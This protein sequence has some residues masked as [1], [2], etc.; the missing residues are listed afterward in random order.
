MKKTAAKKMATGTHF[1]ILQLGVSIWNQWRA[2]EP[3]TVPNLKNADLSELHLE[4]INLCRANLRGAKLAKAYLYDADFQGADLRE[5]NLTRA[6]LIGA[7]LHKANLSG[8]VLKQAYLAQS[9]LSNAD[10]TGAQ[11]QK[12]DLKD[13]LLTQADFANAR[14][15]EAELSTSFDLTQQQLNSTRDA[16]LACFDA[17][18]AAGL[19]LA[20]NLESGATVTA[21]TD[22]TAIENAIVKRRLPAA[23]APAVELA[24]ASADHPIEVLQPAPREPKLSRQSLRQLAAS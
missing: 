12:A 6:L 3:L 7:N 18:V 22:S 24:T 9:D 23:N 20:P 21:S 2:A 17:A 1:A 5:A 15:A 16:H 10:F 14:I 19:S 11:L 8:A 4:N 13:A